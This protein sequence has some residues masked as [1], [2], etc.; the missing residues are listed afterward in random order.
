[1]P[2]NDTR[3]CPLLRYIRT[4]KTT[5]LACFLSIL[6]LSNAQTTLTDLDWL[7]GAW[8]GTMENESVFEATYSSPK[9]G[10]ILSTSKHIQGDKVVF[11][12]FELFERQGNDITVTPYPAGERSVS[13]R[14]V[15]FD[16]ANRIAL[17]ENAEHDFPTQ[18]RYERVSDTHLRIS[19][20]GFENGNRRELI[21][22]LERK[23]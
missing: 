17:F 23:R 18:L 4:M 8:T 14:L 7:E 16:R 9:G 2:S 11:H 6:S 22:D 10:M 12:E 3:K 21:F 20:I 15:E 13:F 19:A 5:I 1:M